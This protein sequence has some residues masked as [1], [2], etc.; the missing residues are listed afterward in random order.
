MVGVSKFMF[1]QTCKSRD[2]HHF[3]VAPL[4]GGR[5]AQV[6]NFATGVI[7]DVVSP[8]TW[9]KTNVNVIPGFLNGKFQARIMRNEVY[10]ETVNQLLEGNGIPE[11]EWY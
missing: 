7:V 6:V 10:I 5:G 11:D 9:S 2:S 8:I 4:G 1:E 3:A